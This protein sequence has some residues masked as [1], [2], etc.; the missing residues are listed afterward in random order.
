MP[1]LPGVFTIVAQ[2][3]FFVLEGFGLPTRQLG[4]SADGTWVPIVEAVAPVDRLEVC[5]ILA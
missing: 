5:R 2:P 3:Q 4:L 1:F